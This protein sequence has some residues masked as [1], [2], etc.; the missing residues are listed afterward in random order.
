M[1][2]IRIPTVLEFEVNGEFDE[3]TTDVDTLK[4]FIVE[5][6]SECDVDMITLE[7]GTKLTLINVFVDSVEEI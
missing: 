7:D 4:E 1:A 2:K 6:I 3:D 5:T